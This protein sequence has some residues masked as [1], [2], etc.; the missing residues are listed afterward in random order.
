MVSGSD[1]MVCRHADNY[2]QVRQD[3]RGWPAVFLGNGSGWNDK[4]TRSIAFSSKEFV[5]KEKTRL[6]IL[7]K[8]RKATETGTGFQFR[9]PV[10]SLCAR[11]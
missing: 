2:E 6:D 1:L 3:H 9:D 8:G 10:G 7:A 5:E 4:W 11:F